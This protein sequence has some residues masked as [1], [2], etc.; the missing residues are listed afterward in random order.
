M[1]IV[2][3]VR[4]G[5]TREEMKR[6][7]NCGN[8]GDEN[9]TKCEVCGGSFQE[10][11]E[12]VSDE[13]ETGSVVK[14]AEES[15]ADSSSRK[16]AGGAKPSAAGSQE[17]TRRPRRTKSGPQI[18]GQNDGMQ[19][20]RLYEQQGMIRRDVQGR[21]AQRGPENNTS[22][23]RPT[24]SENGIQAGRAASGNGTAAGRPME[25]GNGAPANRP[26][27]SGNGAPANRPMGPGNGV[28]AN[29][30]MGPGNGA[31][32]GR[33]MGPGNGAPG[34]PMGPG[35]GV[36]GR[37][38]GPG[39]GVPGR[40]PVKMPNVSPG[41]IMEASRRVIKSPL[42][43]LVALLNTVCLAGSVAAIFMH[44]LNYSQIIRL[45]SSIKM[46][47]QIS[48]YVDS[49]I[50]ILGKLDSGM[51]AV[52][53]AIHIPELLLCI[54]FWLVCINVRTADEKM[55]G[56]GFVFMKV[57]V[58][59]SMIKMCIVLLVGLIV[60]VT[61]VVAAWVSGTKSMIIIAG[62]ML[63][64][65]IVAAMA[66]IMYYFC[67]LATIKVCRL[68]AGTG[69]AYG[70]ASS[71]VAFVHILGALTGGI[72][73]LSG[74]VNSEISNIVGSAGQIGWMLLFAVWIFL[75]RGKMSEFEEE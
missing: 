32:T 53:L 4:T 38:M 14:H 75:Y 27:G 66:I 63:V 45:I 39:N 64:G 31:P 72:G 24:G 10:V 18:Y 3:P 33:P 71:Y 67:Y 11:P 16:A 12:D 1:K 41:R 48:S 40:L 35:N 58:I 69:E 44:Q 60:S 19:N 73:L 25:P 54:G 70:L 61:L 37:P 52:N 51:M 46:P 21:G 13:K 30:P 56:A 50:T 6:C 9:S 57:Y 26:M 22:S 20:A 23:G 65:M 29:R 7:I 15:T 47:T 43:I 28:P 49:L 62:V 2:P 55:S 59:I 74:I 42:L 36:P 5:G 34:R 68:N 17:P 8:P